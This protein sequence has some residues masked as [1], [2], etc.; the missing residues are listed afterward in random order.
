MEIKECCHCGVRVAVKP[1]GTCP[2]CLNQAVAEPSPASGTRSTDSVPASEESSAPIQATRSPLTSDEHGRILA[3]ETECD[4][5][6]HVKPE[7]ISPRQQAAKSIVVAVVFSI[8]GIALFANTGLGAHL[9]IAVLGAFVG[10]ALTLPGVSAAR[11]A[12]VTGGMIAA[13]NLPGPLADKVMDAAIGNESR[14]DNE[15]D[16]TD[17]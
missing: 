7:S 17:P 16:K 12:R 1:D 3:S 11:V 4:A 10:F 2:S 13:R 6:P 14:S 8:P 5:E 9:L 15:P